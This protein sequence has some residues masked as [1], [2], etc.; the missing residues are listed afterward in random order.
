MN[1]NIQ[2]YGIVGV[3]VLALAGGAYYLFGPQESPLAGLGG[4][5]TTEIKPTDMVHGSPSAPIT[6]IEYADLQCPSCAALNPAVLLFHASRRRGAS[7]Q[8]STAITF[9]TRIS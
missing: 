6:I 8:L 2:T 3:V 1:K 4:A 5:Q 7:S 9:L